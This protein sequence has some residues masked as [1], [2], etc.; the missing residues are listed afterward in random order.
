MAK[1]ISVERTQWTFLHF[2]LVLLYNIDR[3]VSS[4]RLIVDMIQVLYTWNPTQCMCVCFFFTP[5][6]ISYVA[7]LWNVGVPTFIHKWCLWCIFN[8]SNTLSSFN[9]SC[10]FWFYESFI[11]NAVSRA[12]GSD[13]GHR[14]FYTLHHKP[15]YI[16]LVYYQH[17]MILLWKRC[18]HH[19]Q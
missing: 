17:N 3:I 8:S 16:K 5:T 15:Y 18:L 12:A 7:A 10:Q 2:V 9:C 14:C 19:Y 4:L 11:V 6:F 1:I 13:G